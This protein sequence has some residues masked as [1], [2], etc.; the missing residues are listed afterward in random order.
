MGVLSVHAARTFSI[1][2]KDRSGTA[3]KWMEDRRG[4]IPGVC[5]PRTRGIIP[6]RRG[7][8]PARL[9]RGSRRQRIRLS[10]NRAGTRRKDKISRARRRSAGPL[11]RIALSGMAAEEEALVSSRV[12]P[13]SSPPRCNS[14]SRGAMRSCGR[15][16][17]LFR[18]RQ[19]MG[20]RTDDCCS[21]QT[22]SCEESTLSGPAVTRRFRFLSL[23]QHI[24][25]PWAASST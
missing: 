3:K 23:P 6:P 14:T 24:S 18:G 8:S 16:S 4:S 17:T 2:G 22:G 5:R 12:P 9:R 25:S 19:G 10:A 11:R 7:P 13:R 20:V 15:L 1:D 21:W